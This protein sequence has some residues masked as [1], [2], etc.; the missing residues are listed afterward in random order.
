MLLLTLLLLLPGA[1]G[2]IP[3]APLGSPVTHASTLPENNGARFSAGN[4]LLPADPA[5]LDPING[6]TVEAWLYLQGTSVLSTIAGKTE[7]SGFWFG[8]QNNKLLLT[9]GTSDT[10]PPKGNLGIAGNEW[11]HV[12]GTF[13]GTTRRYYINGILDLEE[14]LPTPLPLPVNDAALGIGADTAGSRALA[15]AWP[16]CGCGIRPAHAV[17]SAAT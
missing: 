4:S 14:T 9:L 1:T 17:K 2:I 12:A 11:T 6:I 15:G 16:S 8:L 5:G 10:T 13:D 7:G 3:D